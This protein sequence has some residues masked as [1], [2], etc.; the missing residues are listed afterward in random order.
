MQKYEYTI[1]LFFLVLQHWKAIFEKYDLDG[2]GKISLQ[3][4]KAMVCGVEF[5]NDVP[6]EVIRTIM[7]KADLDDSGYLEYPEFIA[8]VGQ[9]LFQIFSENCY[10]RKIVSFFFRGSK[11]Y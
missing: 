7:R 1:K 11:K 5:C 3:E 4:L 2:D 8:M 9:S 6:P 10:I